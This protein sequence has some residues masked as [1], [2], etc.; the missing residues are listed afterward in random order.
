MEAIKM[1]DLSIRQFIESMSSELSDETKKKWEA[2]STLLLS[3]GI[4]GFSKKEL[5]TLLDGRDLNSLSIDE[6]CELV[7]SRYNDKVPKIDYNKNCK[8]M[9]R[10]YRESAGTICYLPEE[11]ADKDA[12]IDLG[13]VRDK[14]NNIITFESLEEASKFSRVLLDKFKGGRMTDVLLDK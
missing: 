7:E 2:L 10:A 1:T 12:D 8:Y 14:T 9:I 13:C 3:E 4:G 11:M 6:Y 5:K